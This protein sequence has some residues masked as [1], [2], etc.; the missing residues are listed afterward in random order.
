MVTIQVGE[1]RVENA[2]IQIYLCSE[3]SRTDK[4]LDLSREQASTRHTH[5]YSSYFLSPPLHPPLYFPKS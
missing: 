1:H 5:D 2:P 4:R 3:L